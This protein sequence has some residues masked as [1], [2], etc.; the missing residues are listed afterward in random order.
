MTHPLL[1]FNYNIADCRRKF[2][3][4][5]RAQK[6]TWVSWTKTVV[7]RGKVCCSAC[8]IVDVPIVNIE[9]FLV[10]F[11]NST[12]VQM[13][14]KKRLKLAEKRPTVSVL[15]KEWSWETMANKAQPCP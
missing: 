15:C 7:G 5:I 11:G 13:W 4:N 9:G 12:A 1:N 8:V 2:L 3:G 10:S 14:A 6:G